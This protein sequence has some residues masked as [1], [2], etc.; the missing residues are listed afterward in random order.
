MCAGMRKPSGLASR[1]ISSRSRESRPRIG[2]PSEPM[3]ADPGQLRVE[4]GHRVQVGQVDQMVDLAG[5]VIPLVDRGDLHG[6]H[7]PHVAPGHRGRQRLARRGQ[8]EQARLG[9]DEV[10][11]Q[12]VVP[13]GMGEVAGAQQRDALASGPPGEVGQVE[14]PAARHGVPRVNVEIGDKCRIRYFGGSDAA[15]RD[16]MGAEGTTNPV[17]SAVRGARR[18]AA[19]VSWISRGG[20]TPRSWTMSPLLGGRRVQ[21]LGQHFLHVRQRRQYC[22]RAGRP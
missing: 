5:A 3:F 21:D 13:G 20:L 9:G 19:S 15:M 7:E 17:T 11:A 2:R 22:F 10:F 1:V 4:P 6:Q 18:H 16:E 12:V 14:L 8:P